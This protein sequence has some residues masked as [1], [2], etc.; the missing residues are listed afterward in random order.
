LVLLYTFECDLRD[1]WEDSEAH[2]D[3]IG[4]RDKA[5]K[6]EANTLN[7]VLNN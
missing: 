1:V 6:M 3:P 7:Y 5:L 4:D 2:N